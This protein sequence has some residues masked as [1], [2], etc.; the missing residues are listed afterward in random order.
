MP[1]VRYDSYE[2]RDDLSNLTIEEFEFIYK[3]NKIANRLGL[4]SLKSL[5]PGGVA[6]V[7]LEANGMLK[8]EQVDALRKFFG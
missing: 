6:L 1:K 2:D 7:A 4:R 5:G 8:P 3:C